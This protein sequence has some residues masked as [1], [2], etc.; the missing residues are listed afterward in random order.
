MEPGQWREA[1]THKTN[2]VN[3]D[4]NAPYGQWASSQ[5]L[6][7]ELGLFCFFLFFL[8]VFFFCFFF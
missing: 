2:A 4:V 7:G 5:W 1:A 8:F 3:I 6:M